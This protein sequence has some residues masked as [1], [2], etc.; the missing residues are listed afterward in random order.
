MGVC[1]RRNLRDRRNL[2]ITS[3]RIDSREEMVQ[4]VSIQMTVSSDTTTD[5]NAKRFYCS[6][7][8]LYV[9]GSQPTGK[10]KRY[11]N[12][13]SDVRLS[14]SR[15]CVQYRLALSPSMIDFLN[16]TKSRRRVARSPGPPPL[17]PA[18]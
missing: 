13:L 8:L 1:W 16:L 10:K 11:I 4:F 5:I 2:R 9:V 14:A 18:Q 15:A 12:R 6:N 3:H 17:T 7:C